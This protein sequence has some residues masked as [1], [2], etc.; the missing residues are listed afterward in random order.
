MILSEFFQPSPGGIAFAVIF[1]LTI[2]V[3][4]GLG[5]KGNHLFFQRVD[6][7]SGQCLQV[8][9]G[10]A[11]FGVGFV[12]AIGREEFFGREIASAIKGDQITAFH[13]DKGLQHLA[14][15]GLSENCLEGRTQQIG[16]DNIKPG[17][18]LGIGGD[19][20]HAVNGL[21]IVFLNLSSAIKSQKGRVF[22]RKH[23][24]AGH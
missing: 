21:E 16:M 7:D 1:G 10:L 18:H 9:G 12:Q 13:E 22:K 4:D 11:G 24:E 2:L 5:W 14:P 20:V 23:G 17:T 8:I 6:N 3:A 15:L 19:L